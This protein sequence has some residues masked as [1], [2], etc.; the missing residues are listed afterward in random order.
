MRPVIRRI[1]PHA[2][3]LTADARRRIIPVR[4]RRLLLVVAL[5][6]AIFPL[7]VLGFSVMAKVHHLLVA[8]G[9]GDVG[10]LTA[11]L[12]AWIFVVIFASTAV[13]LFMS[14]R[15]ARDVMRG[16]HEMLDGMRRVEHNE[17][18]T[19]LLPTDAS[20]FAPL[21]EGFNTMTA[22]LR[23]PSGRVPTRI[24]LWPSCATMQTPSRPCCAGG[25]TRIRGIR[26]VRLASRLPCRTGLTKHLPH[27]S[28]LRRSMWTHAMQRMRA[29]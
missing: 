18:D 25:L 2:G 4:M 17:F 3:T 29:P 26:R 20:E 27:C 1:W 14:E 6:V 15:A 12:W 24:S 22:R 7:L 16:A 19:V 11:P 10:A 13:G 23:L 9:A 28:L 8:A 21:Y 5:F